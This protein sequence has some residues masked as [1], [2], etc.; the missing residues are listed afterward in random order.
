MKTLKVNTSYFIHK[1]FHFIGQVISSVGVINSIVRHL[2]SEKFYTFFSNTLFS[3]FIHVLCIQ[4]IKNIRHLSFRLVLLLCMK[5][6]LP[7]IM[8]FPPFSSFDIIFFLTIGIG[9]EEFTMFYCCGQFDLLF[10]TTS[11]EC[12]IRLFGILIIW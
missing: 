7:F 10:A 12:I 3:Y 5:N 4:C 6:Y 9:I 1:L 2:H 8:L 11:N